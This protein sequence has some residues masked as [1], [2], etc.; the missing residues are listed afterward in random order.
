[1]RKLR[2]AAGGKLER[3]NL[4]KGKRRERRIVEDKLMEIKR[5]IEMR[6]REKRKKI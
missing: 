5:R 3:I 4:K 6:E 1:M 2:G